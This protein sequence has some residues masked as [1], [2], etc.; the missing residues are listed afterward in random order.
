MTKRS[1]ACTRQGTTVLE[2]VVALVITGAVA[3]A[4]AMAFRQAIDRRT[5]VLSRS[6]A[7]ERAAAL[8][9]QLREWLSSGV[10]LW[11]NPTPGVRFTTSAS[12]TGVPAGVELLLYI[13]HDPATA[14]QGL[15]LQYRPA[16]E[17][18][19]REVEID[20]AVSEMVVEYFDS[21]RRTWVSAAEAGATRPLAVRLTLPDGAR[22]EAPA[23]SRLR[24]LPLTVVMSSA[25]EAGANG[26]AGVQP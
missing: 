4:G 7:T 13:D 14:V 8:R 21:E 16:P 22:N 24:T 12:V 1:L 9:G 15:S 23:E 26:A 2:L 6:T 3:A 18:P 17:A 20:A 10:L 11:P 5:E 19:R 25:A